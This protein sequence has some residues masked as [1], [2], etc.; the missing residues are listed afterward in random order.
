MKT[1]RSR[2]TVTPRR[3]IRRHRWS[4]EQLEDRTLL[5]SSPGG[6][7]GDAILLNTPSDVKT[8][9]VAPGSPVFFE[10]ETSADALLVARVQSAGGYTRLSLLDSLGRLLVQSDGQSASNPDDLIEQHIPAG[11]DYLEVQSRGGAGTFVLSSDLAPASEPY[12]PIN[13]GP[14]GPNLFGDFN[15]DGLADLASAAGV[16][17]N[18]GDGTFGPTIPLPVDSFS[19]GGSITSGYFDGTGRLDLAVA[20]G[21]GQSYVIEDLLNNG[22]GKFQTAPTS[23]TLDPTFNDLNGLITG[24][25]EG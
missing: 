6:D 17:L 12:Q 25:F 22:D 10:I 20:I 4:L 15:D 14:S 24:N 1:G 13:E 19:I 2:R 16:Q 11:T 23:L 5:T 8:G 21:G 9:S 18:L 7:I 3:V